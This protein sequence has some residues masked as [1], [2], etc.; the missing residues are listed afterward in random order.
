MFSGVA[1]HMVNVLKFRIHS[2]FK[3]KYYFL[4]SCFSKYSVEW[5]CRPWSDWSWRSSL[6]WV[7]TVCICYFVRPLGV[8]NFK[9]FTIS[10]FFFLHENVSC[11]YHWEYHSICFRREIGKKIIF[12]LVEN[13]PYLELWNFSDNRPQT[14][15]L[16]L[17]YYQT[18]TKYVSQYIM[19]EAPLFIVKMAYVDQPAH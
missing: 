1:D 17:N 12:F 3:P 15:D 6:I 2:I 11:G 4:C 18:E 14:S 7:Y 8:Q 5:Q 16:L 19:G 10:F 13:M 9:T